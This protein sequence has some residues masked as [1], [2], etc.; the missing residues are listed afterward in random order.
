MLW[1]E[2]CLARHSLRTTL[3]CKAERFC[4]VFRPR[5]PPRFW[6][7]KAGSILE[8]PSANLVLYLKSFSVQHEYPNIETGMTD[9][10]IR[11]WASHFFALRS[12]R[13]VLC[14]IPATLPRLTGAQALGLVNAAECPER[15]FVVLTQSDL[16][17]EE[18]VQ[19]MLAMRLM[20][21]T[22]K[23]FFPCFV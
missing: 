16:V 14:A 2:S 22:G 18:R 1:F 15:T 10:R 6:C 12:F 5:D 21:R 7:S 23:T 11:L 20:R 8:L 4:C 19:D 13:S 17:K 9:C 3:S